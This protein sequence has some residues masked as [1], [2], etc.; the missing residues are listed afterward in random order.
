LQSS[1][2]NIFTML[3]DQYIQAFRKLAESAEAHTGFT[4]P[5]LLAHYTILVLADHMRRGNWYPDPSFAE[6]YL[7]LASA[8]KAKS[9]ADECL[10]ICSVFPDYAQRGG[11]SLSYYYTMAQDCY[12]RSAALGNAELFTS[13]SRHFP[14]IVRWAGL[15]VKQDDNIGI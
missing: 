11:V 12:Q 10:F 15:V 7:Q 3:E 5:P 9:L 4:L 6:N 14:H 8:Q 2:L 1:W 13:M